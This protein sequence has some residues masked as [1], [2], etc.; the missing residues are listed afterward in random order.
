MSLLR[1]LTGEGASIKPV[2]P[3]STQ[4]L[5]CPVGQTGT[6]QH[7]SRTVTWDVASQSWA[8][9]NW[10][11]TDYDCRVETFSF[12][13]PVVTTGP[14]GWASAGYWS[15]EPSPEFPD[16]HWEGEVPPPGVWATE[17]LFMVNGALKYD[18]TLT[19]GSYTC[20]I[21]AWYLWGPQAIGYAVTSIQ[22]AG[23]TV[24]AHW[25]D[26]APSY[27]GPPSTWHSPKVLDATGYATFYAQAEPEYGSGPPK[28]IKN[29]EYNGCNV[30][31]LAVS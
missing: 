31:V 2:A 10:N 3:A 15:N 17:N 1:V 18:F 26:E 23:A 30:D 25:Q 7:Q 22:L 4:T 14:G 24:L 19:S 13:G 5:A 29:G 27:K 21:E 9:G 20:R 12:I 6:G 11:T 28:N 16:G 8:V